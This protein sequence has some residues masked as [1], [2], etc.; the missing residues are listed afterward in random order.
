VVRH[1]AQPWNSGTAGYAYGRGRRPD[2]SVNCPGMRDR[3]TGAA[4]R[5]EPVALSRSP[6]GRHRPGAAGRGVYPVCMAEVSS[7]PA[8]WPGS[9]ERIES[10]IAS[11]RPG[12]AGR[13]VYPVCMAEVSSVPAQWPVS[14]EQI[15][16]GIASRRPPTDVGSRFHADVRTSAPPLVKDICTPILHFKSSARVVIDKGGISAPTMFAAT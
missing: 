7:V 9:G 13:G 3:V 6:T 15:D 10:A 12:A 4:V 2:R 11:R 16:S 1:Y 5:P 14:G 8:Q